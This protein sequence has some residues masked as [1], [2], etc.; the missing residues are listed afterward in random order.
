MGRPKHLR[1]TLRMMD[2]IM[3][4]RSFPRQCKKSPSDGQNWNCVE[5]QR[6]EI[7]REIFYVDKLWI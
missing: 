5:I 1:L 6:L 2:A 3:H 4:Q 7:W